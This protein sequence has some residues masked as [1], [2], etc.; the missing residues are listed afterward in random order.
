VKNIK[1]ALLGLGNVGGGVYRILNEDRE[2]IRHKEGI[3]CEVKYV[4]VRD[5][6][7]KRD[8]GI[9]DDLLTD[10]FEKILADDEVSIIG[11]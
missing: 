10:N 11:E 1:I 5:I 6:H 4:L 3:T 7:K 2:S 8:V 9:P